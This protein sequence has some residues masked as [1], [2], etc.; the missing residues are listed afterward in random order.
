MGCS[1]KHILKFKGMLIFC[2]FLLLSLSSYL[3]IHL[4]LDK[5]LMISQFILFFLFVCLLIYYYKKET[6]Y[7]RMFLFII[8]LLCIFIFIL[9]GSLQLPSP[10]NFIFNKIVIIADCLTTIIYFPIFNLCKGFPIYAYLATSVFLCTVIIL[11]CKKYLLLKN[12]PVKCKFLIFTIFLTVIEMEFAC[13]IRY[14]HS[15]YNHIVVVF[16]TWGLW[17]CCIYQLRNKLYI[18]KFVSGFFG[19]LFIVQI[20]SAMG[21]CIAS[22][23]PDYISSLF[24]QIGLSI[25]A[26]L[27][28]LPFS[29]GI[30]PN[31]IFDIIPM[32]ISILLVLSLTIFSKYLQR[33]RQINLPL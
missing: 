4:K 31:T 8:Y 32:I 9:I 6:S 29:I 26:A 7:Q 17:L 13:L 2:P 22:V 23:F 14:F 24:S 30:I 21:I 18:L 16:A 19:G 10:S 20:L 3:V 25:W 1:D 5:S 11:F 12:N 33:K 27:S 28:L 15:P